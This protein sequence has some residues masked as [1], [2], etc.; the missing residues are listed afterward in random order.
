MFLRLCQI[1]KLGLALTICTM[2]L[3]T[4]FPASAQQ[5]LEQTRSGSNVQVL[6]VH[7]I[8]G[9]PA[10]WATMAPKLEA[11][12]YS[13]NIVD[14][15]SSL[16]TEEGSIEAEAAVV[17]REIKSIE[18]AHPGSTVYIVAHSMGG[19][20]ARWYLHDRNLWKLKNSDGHL[21]S[22]VGKLI[23]LG[24]PN[25]GTDI[26]LVNPVATVA[27]S[28]L[29]GGT[30]SITDWS[31][32]L[33]DM[34]A[35]WMPPPTSTDGA[36]AYP[37]GYSA[38]LFEWPSVAPSEF[39]SPITDL[40]IDLSEYIYSLYPSSALAEAIAEFNIAEPGR[41]ATHSTYSGEADA[42]LGPVYEP[43]V[44]APVEGVNAIRVSPFLAALNGDTK[45]YAGVKVYLI[46]GD[47][48]VLAT[49]DHQKVVGPY[50]GT[51]TSDALVP[52]DS[53]LG[54]NPIGD[55][56]LFASAPV[57]VFPANHLALPS[58]TNVIDSVLT[59]LNEK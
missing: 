17:G 6:L 23:M 11:A 12:G 14:F 16:H 39:V 32:G 46:A 33:S 8:W 55:A 10:T 56:K 48:P 5:D 18:T 53:A 25:W 3:A 35:E 43:D 1:C 37:T 38:E 59:W 31:A 26:N 9:S 19:L 47:R 45:P 2:P 30:D 29:L 42:L 50:P 44:T 20:A 51:D 27:V 34:Y 58:D 54:R 49:F 4:T 21:I 15:K 57:K 41:F 24:T 22:C 7:G 13:V 40:S 52:V 36:Y 28:D